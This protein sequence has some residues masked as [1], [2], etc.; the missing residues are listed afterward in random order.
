[1]ADQ[2]REHGKMGK[3]RLL[4]PNLCALDKLA[5]RGGRGQTVSTG[6]DSAQVPNGGWFY[7]AIK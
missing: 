7:F 2:A 6:I 3:K 5:R 1:M 4:N